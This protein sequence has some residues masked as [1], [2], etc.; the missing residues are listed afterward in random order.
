MVKA[1]L[2]NVAF[3]NINVKKIIEQNNYTNQYLNSIGNQLDKIE[4][5][6]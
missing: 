2:F 1:S 3:E 5:K 4:E 6:N